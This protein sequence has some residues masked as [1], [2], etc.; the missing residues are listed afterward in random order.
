MYKAT[1][2]GTELA[3]GEEVIEVEKRLYFRPDDVRQE[4]LRAAPERS[5]CEWKGGE[6]EYFD[7][8]A[9]GQ[10]NRAAAW[11]Y[12]RTGQA[13]RELE[14]RFAFWRGVAISWAGPAPASEPRKLLAALP[15]VAKAIGAIT[16]EWRHPLPLALSGPDRDD[17]SGYL[18]PDQRILVDVLETPAEAERPARV[19]AA[20]AFA[21]RVLKW[22]ADHPSQSYGFIAVWGSA[23]PSP[24]EIAQL[25]TGAVIV[26]LTGSVETRPSTR[27]T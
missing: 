24:Q 5:L 14:G 19:A 27:Q 16:A 25:R 3:L 10:V 15:N 8:V 12:P 22:N 18:I 2:N 13:A 9:G 23:T 1:W 21:R 20:Q 4:A 6:A 17:F 26:A 7:I 11:R